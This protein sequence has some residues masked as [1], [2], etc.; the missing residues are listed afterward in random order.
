M[1]KFVFDM[2]Q[3][4]ADVMD[5]VQVQAAYARLHRPVPEA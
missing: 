2:R 4:Y 1:N 5:C 3:K